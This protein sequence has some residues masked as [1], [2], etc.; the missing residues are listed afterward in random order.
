MT[1]LEYRAFCDC[2][3][4]NDVTFGNGL[5]VIDLGAFDMCMKLTSVTIPKSVTKLK[6]DNCNINDIYYTGSEFDWNKIDTKEIDGSRPLT[7]L[8]IHYNYN[9]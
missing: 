7:D 8:T 5:K 2:E 1:K 3:N 9:K 4:L 6:G